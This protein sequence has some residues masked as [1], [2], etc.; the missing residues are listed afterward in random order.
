[1]MARASVFNTSRVASLVT[2]QKGEGAALAREM[3]HE[4]TH[5]AAG[6]DTHI[7]RATEWRRVWNC[8]NDIAWIPFPVR[9]RNRQG[10]VST[11]LFALLHLKDPSMHLRAIIIRGTSND[12]IIAC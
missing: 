9:W 6:A 12:E 4:L 3:Q 7:Q 5:H 1:M 10:I 11:N 8:G 2:E